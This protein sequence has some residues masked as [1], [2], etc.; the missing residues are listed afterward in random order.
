MRDRVRER[1]ELGVRREQLRRGAAER[2]VPMLE[3]LG[4]LRDPL[5]QYQRVLLQLL[6]LLLDSTE[7]LVERVGQCAQFVLAEL[8]GSH[9]IVLTL[10]TRCSVESRSRN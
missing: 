9:G 6:F 7:H 10:S 8:G 1:I 5:F 2:L 3:L 4:A